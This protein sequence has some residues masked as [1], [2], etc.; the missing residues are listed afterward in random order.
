MNRV[1]LTSITQGLAAA[2]LACALSLLSANQV[3]ANPA[4]QAVDPAQRA[5]FMQ[6][7][8]S[9]RAGDRSTFDAA[10]ERLSDY[11]LYPY[12]QYEDFRYRRAVADPDEVAA[13][14]DAHEDWAFVTALRR[15]WL[16][17]LG[18]RG[19]W[20]ALRRYGATADTDENRCYH[21]RARLAEN[22]TTGLLAQARDLWAVGHSQPD[23]CDP[24]FAWMMKQGGVDAE[25]AWTRINRAMAEGNASLTAYLARFL[26]PADQAWLDR[27]RQLDRTRYRGLDKAAAWPDTPVT[28]QITDTSLRKLLRRDPAEAMRVFTALD[29]HFNWGDQA[30]GDLMREIALMATVDLDPGARAFIEQVPDAHVDDQ[31]TQWWARLLLA[32]SDWPALLQVIER[33]APETAD[34]DRWRYWKGH[35]LASLDEGDRAET[36]FSSLA[37]ETNYYAFLAADALRWPYTICEIPPVVPDDVAGAVAGRNDIR[38]ALELHRVDLENWARAEWGR[39]MRR[40]D[41]EELRAAAAVARGEGWYDRAIFALGDSGDLRWYEWRFPVMFEEPVLESARRERLDA[42]WVYGIMRSESAMMESAR[43][44]ANALG[45]MQ[46]TPATASTLSRKHGIGYRSSAQLLDGPT[47][48]RFGTTYLRDLLDDYADNPVLVSGAYNAGPG[49]VDRWLKSRP[50]G[51]AAAWVE[52]L[53]YYETRDYI[54]RVLAFTTIY[55]WRLGQPVR[56]VSARM[57]DIESGN[58]D[59]DETTEVVCSAGPADMAAVA[60]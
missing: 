22:D 16:R 9:A 51:N 21:A 13:F 60:P 25:L 38:R 50:K 53:P 17:A 36:I 20:A 4:A 43:S 59:H 48:I 27:W 26:A 44:S 10:G 42:A 31:L 23:A 49:A 19:H 14:L 47:N 37:R 58:I 52:T 11:I 24:L 46:V 3:S 41:V 40:L 34:D 2:A 55:E 1:H 32:Q 39:S 8:Q 6:A 33:M 45:L 30:R 29:G 28:R 12:W 56:R 15:S 5:L 54:P 57:P 18:E 35:A 7:W